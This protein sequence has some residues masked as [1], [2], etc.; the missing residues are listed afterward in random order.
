MVPDWIQL[1]LVQCK[2]TSKILD[3]LRLKNRG[4]N[5]CVDSAELPSAHETSRPLRQVMYG[6]LRLCCD[7]NPSWEVV[8]IDR[9]DLNLSNIPVQPI[10]TA[11]SKQLQLNSLHQVMLS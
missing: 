8:E 9:V 7:L 1:R 6:L 11:T 5:Y 10:D 4:L 2:M 3:V